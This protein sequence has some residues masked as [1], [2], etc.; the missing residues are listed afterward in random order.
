M[1]EVG[2][3]YDVVVR[4][5]R[6]VDGSDE[7]VMPLD[8]L[9]GFEEAGS[10]DAAFVVQSPSPGAKLYVIPVERLAELGDIRGHVYVMSET[11]LRTAGAGTLC[12]PTIAARGA[13]LP[14]VVYL[15]RQAVVAL[16]RVRVDDAATIAV[17]TPAGDERTVTPAQLY[18]SG[19]EIRDVPGAVLHAVPMS[20]LIAGPAHAITWSAVRLDDSQSASE[21]DAPPPARVP[22]R[23]AGDL[24]PPLALGPSI[25]EPTRGLA[26][27]LPRTAIEA[28]VRATLAM[29]RSRTGSRGA[30]PPADVEPHALHAAWALLHLVTPLVT[31]AARS[32][33][34]AE[35]AAVIGAMPRAPD[36]AIAVLLGIPAAARVVKRETTDAVCALC[37][38]MCGG[39]AAVRA[40]ASG[41]EFLYR[42]PFELA[43]P[44]IADR[45]A[46]VCD[47]FAYVPA[48]RAAEVAAEIA[49][50]MGTAVERACMASGACGDVA[51]VAVSA[52]MPTPPTV[53]RA[54]VLGTARLHAPS[55]FHYDALAMLADIGSLSDGGDV[56]LDVDAATA[57]G[58]APACVH[59]FFYQIEA[60]RD[61]PGGVLF[62][63]NFRREAMRCLMDCGFAVDRVETMLLAAVGPAA[64]ERLDTARPYTAM[65]RSMAVHSTKSSSCYTLSIATGQ[66]AVLPVMC[67]WSGCADPARRAHFGAWLHGRVPGL[68]IGDI[69]DAYGTGHYKSACKL[70][71][72]RLVRP[73]HVPACNGFKLQTP[74]D[75]IVFVAQ[76]AATTKQK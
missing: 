62:T 12:E 33:R 27:S 19:M 2:V 41:A 60:S 26:E 28:A 44:A 46:F 37:V 31:G 56:P 4:A 74:R 53:D 11:K 61:Q 5:T 39:D 13:L 16:S 67:P 50:T 21:D 25:E 1:T 7:L 76:R 55:A 49:V 63:Y 66:G 6:G 59:A 47:G 17:R 3:L 43:L 48:A 34:N 54:N 14:T 52:G 35:R 29:A 18:W 72:A 15:P 51:V 73:E 58:C 68:G 20:S 64:R 9:D 8:A 38:R 45:T 75:F 71:A 10:S 57:L 42:V 69:E 40:L 22:C 65:A 36:A 23:A 30:A 24:P 32:M 70:H